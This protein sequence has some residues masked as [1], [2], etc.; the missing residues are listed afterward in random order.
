MNGNK[1]I[2][3]RSYYRHTKNCAILRKNLV[4]Q[5]IKEKKKQSL[6]AVQGV[7]PKLPPVDHPPKGASHTIPTACV[8]EAKASYNFIGDSEILP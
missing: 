3:C 1:C 2:V 5:E 6:P 8:D 4:E 7:A